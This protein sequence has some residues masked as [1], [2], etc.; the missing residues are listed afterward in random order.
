[1]TGSRSPRRLDGRGVDSYGRRAS[2]AG[3]GVGIL[4]TLIILL[5][6]GVLGAGL[7]HL[8]YLRLD[9]ESRCSWDHPL[10]QPARTLCLQADGGEKVRGYDTKARRELDNLIG[11][12]VK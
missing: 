9:R 4:R 11:S 7:F 8:Y 12:A 5:L 1:M 3:E 2:V 6:G 10:D